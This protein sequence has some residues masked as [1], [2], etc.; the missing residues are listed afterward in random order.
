MPVACPEQ[1]VEV[2]A[3]LVRPARGAVARADLAAGELRKR[4]RNQALLEHVGDLALLLVEPRA[5]ERLCRLSR[6]RE[7]K[8]LLVFG[9]CPFV[10]ERDTEHPEEVAAGRDGDDRHG[11]EGQGPA[12]RLLESLP[13]L[14]VVQPQWPLG[15]EHLTDHRRIISREE[16]HG[17]RARARAGP[18][19]A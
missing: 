3:G 19:R 6:N 10:V 1:V 4:L 16:P 14:P 8:R 15:A 12:D 11:L 5:V 17:A 2:A 9:K 18:R 13:L 7:Q